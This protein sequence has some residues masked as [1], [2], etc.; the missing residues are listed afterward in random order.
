MWRRL[1]QSLVLA[2]WGLW[3]CADAEV[4]G[5]AILAVIVGHNGPEQALDKIALS[6]IFLRMTTLWASGEAIQPVNLSSSHPLR[7]AF[8]ERVIG[9]D[10]EELEDYWNDQ[11]FHG[12]FPPYSVAS[13]EAV[14]RYVAESKGAIGYVSACGV[15]NRVKV[16]LYLTPN[17]VAPG[18]SAGRFCPPH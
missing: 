13:E 7:K 16:L 12:V 14:L 3:G 1:G 10:P 15:D 9:L 6:R 8:S 5:P 18:N 11:Y 2:L 17:G 4:G